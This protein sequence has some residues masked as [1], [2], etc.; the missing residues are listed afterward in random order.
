MSNAHTPPY[1]LTSAIVSLVSQASAALGRI[2]AEQS[3]A[4]MLLNTV[5]FLQALLFVTFWPV[6]QEV[7]QLDAV[8]IGSPE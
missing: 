6:A 5:K 8:I 4:S 7:A 1:S 3:L 2:E